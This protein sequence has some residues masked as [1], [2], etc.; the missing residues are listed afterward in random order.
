MLG[1]DEWA[2]AR[3]SPRR[4]RSLEACKGYVVMAQRRK[5][6]MKHMNREQINQWIRWQQCKVTLAMVAQYLPIVLI[7]LAII[8]WILSRHSAVSR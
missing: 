5:T 3:T 1:V 7:P 2:A 4:R 8:V 6:S